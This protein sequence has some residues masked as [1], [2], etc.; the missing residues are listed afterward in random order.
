MTLLFNIN[1]EFAYSLDQRPIE[2]LAKSHAS[3]SLADAILVSGQ[4]HRKPC[5]SLRVG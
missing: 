2:L 1:V 3:S 5:G 4:Y